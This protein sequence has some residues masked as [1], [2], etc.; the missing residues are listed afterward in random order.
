MGVS[1]TMGLPLMFEGQKELCSNLDSSTTS[2]VISLGHN[3]LRVVL[4]VKE[5]NITSRP[6]PGTS[7]CPTNSSSYHPHH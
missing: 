7:T 1:Q 2:C 6:M 3:F 5:I 4:S